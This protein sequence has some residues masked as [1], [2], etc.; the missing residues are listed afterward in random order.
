MERPEVE[1]HEE[2]LP[3]ILETLTL[4]ISP[5]PNENMTI[6]NK[7]EDNMFSLPELQGS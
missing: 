4:G 5:W 7:M 1:D 3:D 6:R 2:K